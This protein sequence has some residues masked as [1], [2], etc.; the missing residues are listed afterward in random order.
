MTEWI[1]GNSFSIIMIGFLI[2]FFSNQNLPENLFPCLINKCYTNIFNF[3][4]LIF[5]ISSII[6]LIIGFFTFLFGLKKDEDKGRDIQNL[7]R[8]NLEKQNEKL[9]LEIEE[10]RKNNPSPPNS[11]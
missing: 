1:K 6:L 3:I 8:D 11:T 2:Y 9:E 10:L 5:Y 7:Q 4:M